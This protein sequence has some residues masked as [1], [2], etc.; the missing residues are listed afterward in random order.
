MQQT[1]VMVK[2]DGVQRALVGEVI[3]RIEQKG[4]RLAAMKMMMIPR[5]TAE[6]H[7]QEHRE[8]PFFPELIDFITS[9]PVV[10]MVWEG[11]GVAA[12]VRTLMGKTNP[13][14]AAPGT[15]RGDFGVS[16]NFNIIHGSDSE[17]SGR[18]EISLFFT[19][20]ELIAWEP[21][22]QRWI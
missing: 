14:E 21:T 20:D 10:A 13:L 3:R 5:S 4:F 15:I 9:G 12:S 22:R 11:E 18:R 2:P 16:I 7:Y 17:E 6:S 19:E 8:R 1:F